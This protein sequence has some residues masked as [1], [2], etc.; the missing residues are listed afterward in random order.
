MFQSSTV[1]FF[2][3]SLSTRANSASRAYSQLGILLEW[4]CFAKLGIISDTALLFI[5]VDKKVKIAYWVLTLGLLEDTYHFPIAVRS[6]SLLLS[7]FVFRGPH[8]YVVPSEVAAPDEQSYQSAWQWN[9]PHIWSLHTFSDCDSLTS[10]VG[11]FVRWTRAAVVQQQRTSAKGSYVVFVRRVISSDV[12]TAT[13]AFRDR[14]RDYIQ[15]WPAATEAG[16]VLVIAS[17]GAPV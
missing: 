16:R 4:F 3:H 13:N 11:L 8:K 6:H 12:A 1:Q 17:W 15:R 2:I 10:R 7:F 9:L 5:N 14:L